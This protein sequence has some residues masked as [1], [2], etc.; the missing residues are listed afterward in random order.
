MIKGELQRQNKK[1]FFVFKCTDFVLRLLPWQ[2]QRYA[3]CISN[4]LN[5]LP[6]NFHV[7]NESINGNIVELKLHHGAF[8]IYDVT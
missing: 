6:V 3:S 1:G 5:Y 4:M 8:F 7:C 2:W